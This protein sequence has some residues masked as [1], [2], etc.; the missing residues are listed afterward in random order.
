MKNHGKISKDDFQ[1]S[2]EDLINKIGIKEL[3]IE[4]ASLKKFC[5]LTRHDYSFYL[6]KNLIPQGYLMTFTIPIFAQFFILA[7]ADLIPKIIKGVIHTFSRI[8]YYEPFRTDQK[9]FGK[10]EI[11]NV[12]E[13]KGKLG[14]YFAADFEFLLS[15]E[16]GEKVASDIHQFFFRI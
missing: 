11:K 15:N 6:E 10:I 16:Q 3:N 4:K 13:K 1:G 2:L 9:Y 7:S 5:E 12:V 14:E 8:E